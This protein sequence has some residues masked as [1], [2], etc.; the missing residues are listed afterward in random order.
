MT[1]VALVGPAAPVVEAPLTVEHNNLMVAARWT[2]K[3]A[4]RYDLGWL[5]ITLGEPIASRRASTLDRRTR[6]RRFTTVDAVEPAS[7]SGR[8][9]A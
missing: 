8:Q 6:Q 7:T 1:A 3:P 2:A 9:S 5:S 4:H